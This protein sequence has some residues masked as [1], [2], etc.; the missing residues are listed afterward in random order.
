MWHVCHRLGTGA[1]VGA[2]YGFFADKFA[3]HTVYQE[4]SILLQLAVTIRFFI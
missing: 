4:P 3:F 1:S 2:K